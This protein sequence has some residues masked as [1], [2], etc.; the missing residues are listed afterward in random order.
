MSQFSF[1]ACHNYIF[2][3]TL[4]SNILFLLC[5][6]IIIIT[7]FLIKFR[8][9]KFSTNNYKK[10]KQVVVIVLIIFKFLLLLLVLCY[11]YHFF[12]FWQ[13]TTYTLVV[14]P[15]FKLPTCGLEFDTLSTW[16]KYEV[17]FIFFTL[18]AVTTQFFFG[19]DIM[20]HI[21]FQNANYKLLILLKKNSLRTNSL[22]VILL[23]I[24][25]WYF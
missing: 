21:H 3:N 14:W 5:L 13:I 25:Y 7:F 23:W 11:W 2:K 1:S 24:N 22:K 8:W 9:N 6:N 16:E 17:V 20:I 10:Y 4:A 19:R 15:K 12:F 18:I